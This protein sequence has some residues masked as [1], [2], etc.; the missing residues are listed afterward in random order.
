MVKEIEELNSLTYDSIISI[1][2]KMKK[3]HESFCQYPCFTLFDV[4]ILLTKNPEIEYSGTT[5]RLRYAD[6]TLE[7]GNVSFNHFRDCLNIALDDP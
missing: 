6:K 3:I 2:E 5:I 7:F 1:Y 4:I